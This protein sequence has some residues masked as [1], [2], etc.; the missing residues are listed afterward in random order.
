MDLNALIADIPDLPSLPRA[1]ALLMAELKQPEPQLRR[2]NQWFATDPALAARLLQLVNTK[3]CAGPREIASIPEA[4]ALVDNAQLHGLVSTALLGTTSGSV[5]GV[6]MQ[7]FW[8]YSVETAKLARSLAGHVHHSQ[9]VAYTAGLLHALGELVIQLANPTRTRILNTLVAPLGLRRAVLETQI[10]GFSYG[11][12]S[13]A[14]ARHWQ[15]PEVVVDAIE[16]H[17]AP[18]DSDKFEP[19]AGIV[20]LAA[21][22]IRTREQGFNVLELNESFPDEVALPLGLDIDMV[23]RQDPFDWTF[24][25]GDTRAE[26]LDTGTIC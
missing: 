6:N 2:L 22:R 26:A 19:L 17:S 13:G 4:L 25:R 9:G 1:I 16:H 11:R 24:L 3:E 21:W 18:F 15:Y 5:P 7:Q 23:L 20:H 12:V 8:R 14:L 10:F